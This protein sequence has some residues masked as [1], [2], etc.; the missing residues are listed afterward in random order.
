MESFLRYLYF[1]QEYSSVKQIW[2]NLFPFNENVT[3]RL[4]RL[5]KNAYEIFVC[6]IILMRLRLIILPFAH[7]RE[8][9][10]RI[11]ES[12]KRSIEY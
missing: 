11:V 3:L 2:H 9:W 8:A 6:A 10:K 12:E 1:L 7:N 4:A 5:T